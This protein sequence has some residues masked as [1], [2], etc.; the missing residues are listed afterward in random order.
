MHKTPQGKAYGVLGVLDCFVV[1]HLAMKMEEATRWKKQQD[2]K[3]NKMEKTTRWKKQQDGK[4][5]K[6]EK[7]TRWKKQQDEKIKGRDIKIPA[8]R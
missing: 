7:T 5:N 4:N 3:N 2:E 1:T 6:M 8:F